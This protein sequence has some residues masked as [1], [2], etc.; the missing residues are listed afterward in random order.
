MDA[1]KF[2]PWLALL[3]AGGILTQF[4]ALKNARSTARQVES[5]ANAAKEKLP[6][7]IDSITVTGAEKAV[8][9]MQSVNES[10]RAE[11]TRRGEEIK[12]LNEARARDHEHI[13]RLG[14]LVETLREEL[15]TARTQAVELIHQLG[16]ADRRYA[17]CKAELEAS[18]ENA[19]NPPSAE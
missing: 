6:A 11:I 16:V 12:A 9:M 17:E 1:E 15:S 10:L 13:E 4:A 2:L 18:R 19:A 7:E 8:L 3:F 5:E 14:T